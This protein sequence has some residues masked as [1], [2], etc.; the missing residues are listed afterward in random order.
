[1]DCVFS[2][3]GWSGGLV[4]MR[5]V[6]V[7]VELRSFSSNHIDVQVGEIEAWRFMGFY[8]Y[9]EDGQKWKSWKLLERLAENCSH[10]G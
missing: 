3:G 7:L 1:M 5:K 9:S 6:D 10:R 2:G 4:S 8:G